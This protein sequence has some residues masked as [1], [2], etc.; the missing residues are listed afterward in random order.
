MSHNVDIPPIGL[1]P[2]SRVVYANGDALAGS[3]ADGSLARPYASLQAAID[4]RPAATGGDPFLDDGWFI[5]AE[6]IFAEN[7][8]LPTDGGGIVIGS[9]ST[10]GRT[11]VGNPAGGTTITWAAGSFIPPTILVLRNLTVWSSFVLSGGIA[12]GFFFTA[13]DCLF[14]G[15]FTSSGSLIPSS[16][17]RFTR[18]G[19]YNGDPTFIDWPG[20]VFFRSCEFSPSTQAI[21]AYDLGEL[22]DCG[23]VYSNITA[24]N[25]LGTASEVRI[26][27]SHF[28]G[29]VVISHNLALI[30]GCI[31]EAA[32]SGPL[33]YNL[34][35]Y[36]P[37]GIEDCRFKSGGNISDFKYISNSVS[38]GNFVL[39][40]GSFHPDA[41]ITNSRFVGLFQC[42]SGSIFRNAVQCEF[43][44]ITIDFQP[45]GFFLCKIAGT[46]TGPPNS[47]A[48]DEVT[49]YLSTVGLLGGATSVYVGLGTPISTPGVGNTTAGDLALWDDADGTALR[50]GNNVFNGIRV[51]NQGSNPISIGE[52]TGEIFSTNGNLAIIGDNALLLTATGDN[53]NLDAGQ[54]LI[55][56]DANKMSSGYVGDLQLT[57]TPDEWLDF[58]EV[59]G[60]SASIFGAILEAARPEQQQQ[61][62]SNEV[63]ENPSGTVSIGQFA[64]DA[65][66][67]S[68]G[69]SRYSTFRLR[70]VASV[71]AAV[72]GTVTLYNLTDGETVATI[73][74]IT[75]T[76]P[77]KYD[78]ALT[79]GVAAGN[80][81]TSEK[82]YEVRASVTGTT[83]ADI[84]TVGGAFLSLS[85]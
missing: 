25:N 41:N 76:A 40:G 65:S 36:P 72:T 55:L 29:D 74:T 3:T 8:V 82:I 68:K 50:Q 15:N 67:Y 52:N 28:F 37:A 43:A 73:S 71:S 23:S 9:T 66:L 30:S 14:E 84:I 83:S 16:A 20:A 63:V 70:V 18:C 75:N 46:L 57:D 6:G 79:V 1:W 81:K 85:A 32:F 11:V 13:T 26:T 59:F 10:E 77:T 27:N 19:F 33:G 39:N 22:T 69:D 34:N 48:R 4:A 7:L 24:T 47:Y 51:D 61:I 12:A 44:N 80:L 78:A 42:L 64:F 17:L 56:N 21:N 49:D 54:F 53:L 5:I 45:Q 58:V 60:S 35:N 2:A 31:F 62:A 38:D